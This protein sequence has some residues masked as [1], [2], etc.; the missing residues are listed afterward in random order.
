MIYTY[1]ELSTGHLT[2]ETLDALEAAN[3]KPAWMVREDWPAMTI[4]NYAYGVFI[5]VPNL[6]DIDVAGQVKTLPYE[7]AGCLAHA[8][9][10]GIHLLRF[11]SEGDEIDG[12][13]VFDDEAVMHG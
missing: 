12:L 10:K 6:S 4:A 9:A 5:T 8:H 1:L 11:D 7:L 3:D 2:R 13:P